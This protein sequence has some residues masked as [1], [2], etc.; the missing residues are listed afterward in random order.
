[1]QFLRNV[2][3]KKKI[4]LAIFDVN[5]SS[6]LDTNIFGNLVLSNST[7]ERIFPSIF[8]RLPFRS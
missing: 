5:L 8:D 4:R 6:I 3:G 7:K 2:N 1:M